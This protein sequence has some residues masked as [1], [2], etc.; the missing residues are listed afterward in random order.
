M[1]VSHNCVLTIFS[2]C[3]QPYL[4]WFPFLF[5]VLVL[6]PFKTNLWYPNIFGYMVFHYREVNK[7]ITI[8]D[9]TFRGPQDLFGKH[10]SE[11]NHIPSNLLVICYVL[12]LD[13]CLFSYLQFFVLFCYS[14]F[15]FIFCILTFCQMYSLKTFLPH[16]L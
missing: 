11:P 16:C 3:S 14:W 6:K 4:N 10:S 7:C 15:E 12:F 2:S 1:G 9:S 8:T 5:C 13:K